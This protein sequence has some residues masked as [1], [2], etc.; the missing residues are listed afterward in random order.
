MTDYD[1]LTIGNAIVDIIAQTDDAFL[2]TYFDVMVPP[3][4][5]ADYK[6]WA[7]FRIDA[8]NEA[9]K[10]LPADRIRRA[11]ST[12]C[13]HPFNRPSGCPRYERRLKRRPRRCLPR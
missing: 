4:S 9:I 13:S 6:K 1:V 12:S 11:W 2:A 8:T 10:G 7:A 5:F 3:A